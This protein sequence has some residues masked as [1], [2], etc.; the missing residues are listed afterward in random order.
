MAELKPCKC[1]N[2]RVSVVV[3]NAAYSLGAIEDTNFQIICSVT[4]FGCGASSGWHEN[5][6]EAIEAWNNLHSEEHDPVID[7]IM[8]E[9]DSAR[10]RE[11]QS[12]WL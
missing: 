4:S 10:E 8:Q 1:G 11:M 9:E 3:N 12:M 7:E 5:K 6:E 2:K